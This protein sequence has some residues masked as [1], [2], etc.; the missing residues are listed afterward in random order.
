GLVPLYG[1]YHDETINNLLSYVKEDL[2]YAK[3]KLGW[4]PALGGAASHI[5]DKLYDGGNNIPPHYTALLALREYVTTTADEYREYMEP[6]SAGITMYWDYWTE[7]IDKGLAAF[8]EACDNIARRLITREPNPT[9]EKKK[10]EDREDEKNFFWDMSDLNMESLIEDYYPEEV[11]RVKAELAEA[12]LY[13]ESFFD[14]VTMEL[15]LKGVLTVDMVK[16]NN[17]SIMIIKE[18][19]S[20]WVDEYGVYM[21]GIPDIIIDG[22]EI[23]LI[24]DFM[25]MLLLKPLWSWIGGEIKNLAAEWIASACT[26]MVSFV[27]G[28]PADEAAE[29]IRD[30]ISLIDDLLEDPELQLDHEPNPYKPSEDNFADLNEYMKHLESE[31]WEEF[32]ALYNTL[33]MFRLVLM[34]P[35]NYSKFV[36]AYAGGAKQTA[37]QTNTAHLEASALK[38]RIKTSDLYEAG[39]NHNIYVIVYQKMGTALRQIQF[40]LLDISGYDDFEGGHQDDYIIELPRA[41]KL[42]EI[43]IALVKTPAYD[44]TPAMTDDWH[45]ENI[46]VIPMYAGYELTSPIDLGGVHLRGINNIIKMNFQEALK[47]RE[48]DNVKS[49]NVTNLQVQIKVKDELNA[50]TNSDVYLVA[51][52]GDKAYVKV[53]LDKGKGHDDLERGKTEIYDIPIGKYYGNVIQHIP[54][55]QLNIKI[56]HDGSDTAAWESVSIT[57][58]YGDL[59]L[60]EGAVELGGK[61]FQNST[62]DTNFQ[63]KLKKVKY[64]QEPDM[65]QIVTDLKVQVLV[66]AQLG[67]GTDN[68]VSL[69]AYNG[70]VQKEYLLDKDNY[71]DLEMGDND[72]YMVPLSSSKAKGIP[73]N[74]L[75]IVFNHVADEDEIDDEVFFAE[76]LVTPC[77]GSKELT[78]PISLGGKKLENSTWDTDFQTCLKLQYAP[79]VIEYETNLDDGLLSY[80][81]SLDGGEEW[82]DS[83]NELW[84]NTTLRREIFLKIFKGFEPEISFVTYNM[85]PEDNIFDLGF[86]FHGVWNGVSNERRSQVKDFEHIYPVEG[87]ADVDVI[88][89]KG[90]VVKSLNGMSVQD[91]SAKFTLKTDGWEEGSYD[92]KVSYS[93]DY[94]NPLYSRTTM[95]FEDVVKVGG[96]QVNVTPADVTV[97]A[98]QTAALTAEVSGGEAPYTYTWQVLKA[99]NSGNWMTVQNGSNYAGQGTDTLSFTSN[100]PGTAH[101]RCMV[102][103][104][105]GKS[106]TSSGA[107]ITVKETIAPL[108]ITTQPQSTTV[109]AGQTAAFTVA[110]V[111]GK[112]PYTYTWQIK[113]DRGGWIDIKNN[114][115]FSGQGT[116]AL[117]CTPNTE[118][119]IHVRC[120]VKDSIGGN[121]SSEEASVMAVAATIPLSIT[122]QPKDITVEAGQ[123]AIFTVAASGGKLPYTYTWQIPE[124]RGGGWSDISANNSSYTG[125]GTNTLTYLSDTARSS[126]V[127]CVVKDANGDTV[128]S[129]T[130]MVTVTETTLPLAITSQPKDVTLREGLPASVSVEVSG[131]KAPY[132]YTWQIQRGRSWDVLSDSSEV[133]GQGTNTLILTLKTAGMATVRCVI[134]DANG[135]TVTTDTAKVTATENAKPLAITSQPRSVTAEAGQKAVLTVEA[136]GGRAPYAYEW[137]MSDGGWFAI[138]DSA[139]RICSGLDSNTLT[140]VSFLAETTEIRCVVTDADGRFVISEPADVTVTASPLVILTQPQDAVMDVGQTETFFVE[141]DGGTAP[142]TYSWRVSDKE[143]GEIN[144]NNSFIGNQWND[145]VS[146]LD[147]DGKFE[148]KNDSRF[149]GADTSKVYYT[150]NESGTIGLSCVVTDSL[151]NTVTSD[152]AIVEVIVTD[153]DPLRIDIQSQEVI[154]DIGQIADLFVEV[155][156]GKEPYKYSWQ[157]LNGNNWAILRESDQHSG[158][159]GAVLSCTPNKTGTNLYRCVITDADGNSITS[160]EI[161]LTVKIS[162][163]RAPQ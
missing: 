4:V 149:F 65:S 99:D 52:N 35:E 123:K 18:E 77:N 34:G 134:K 150:P 147:K 155:A 26:G 11:E 156:G 80:M 126:I 19:L 42:D 88:N 98:G 117:Q 113:S 23:P 74:E 141:V 160:D 161:I 70:V 79:I 78:V 87:S 8:S 97:E 64:R 21:L 12:E 122:T 163:P 41:L 57:P 131:G 109:E 83:D 153:N 162:K 68:D 118:G 22:I 89:E 101:I 103:D 28:L 105:S 66:S 2:E 135:D 13:G 146:V 132:T 152:E 154:V 29:E 112:T 151:G 142:Y 50:G 61:E 92:L 51:Y 120:V 137:Q 37:Y 144:N 20:Y 15:I 116:T 59:P 45:C 75:N 94:A 3:D 40:K 32:E 56:E 130:A 136:S 36:S 158:Q 104:A 71:N 16:T 10:E 148:A 25:D 60:I 6:V 62:W 133:L 38:V 110:A 5:I 121:V 139:N 82:V 114:S 84:A 14:L 159:G 17:S 143:A 93:P 145:F 107:T 127:R 47:A 108:T 7:D 85:A 27:S 73:L 33:V 111:G 43:E 72:I 49:Q 157:S 90:N 48:P 86:D 91:G 54:L 63:S 1:K 102:K 39:T 96:L 100:N 128:T 124:R 44:F 55:D 24:G 140:I 31:D 81:G 119:I 106:G 58:C 129:N 53:C 95:T 67:A 115:Q 138:E 76:V 125:Q 46:R 30:L 69:L 9:I